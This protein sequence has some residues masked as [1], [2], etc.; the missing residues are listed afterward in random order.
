MCSS[1]PFVDY[2]LG[3]DVNGFNLINEGFRKPIVVSNKVGLRMMVPPPTFSL[4]DVVKYTDPEIVIDVID[5]ALQTDMKLTLGEF[6]D[7]FFQKP[8]GRLLNV[9]S[10]EYSQTK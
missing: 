5:V 10:F 4:R 2:K 8:R 7:R 1:K 9:L 6:V 3:E